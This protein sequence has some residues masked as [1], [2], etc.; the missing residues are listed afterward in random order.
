MSRVTTFRTTKK[1]SDFDERDRGFFFEAFRDRE[2]PE[3]FAPR[4]EEEEKAPPRPED[5]TSMSTYTK[6]LQ[7]EM[8]INNVEWIGYLFDGC[9]ERT[10]ENHE[11]YLVLTTPLF[12][13]NKN[14]R[15]RLV[16]K[17]HHLL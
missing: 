9:F 6:G 8:I 12:K 14:T 5:D 3:D 16:F 4:E 1:T 13:H 10:K 17:Y 15:G 2:A 7:G 11:Y